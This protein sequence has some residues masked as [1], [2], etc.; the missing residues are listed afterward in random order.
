MQVYRGYANGRQEDDQANV[1]PRRKGLDGMLGWPRGHATSMTLPAHSEET[2]APKYH[3]EDEF[4]LRLRLMRWLGRQHW[5]TRGGDAVLRRLHHPDANRHYLFEVDFFGKRYRGDLAHYIDWVVFCYGGAPLKELAL[6]RE[7][8]AEVRRLRPGPITCYDVGANVGHH[9]LFMSGI[10]DRVI[11]FEPFAA[12]RKQMEDK[13][14]L[15]HIKNVQI[16]PVALGARDEDLAY[17][18]GEGANSGIG[19]FV[20]ENAPQN[21]VSH[22]LP[23]RRG[24][25]LFTEKALPVIDILK[26][27]VEGFE[28]NVFEGLVER[29]AHD[30]PVIVTEILDASRSLIGGDAAFRKFFYEGAVFAEVQGPLNSDKFILRPYR[31]ETSDEVVIVPPEMAEFIN[32]RIVR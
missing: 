16:I 19:T 27:D 1:A 22:V 23:V 14:S 7:L 17:F 2:G 5:W 4:P 18:P 31:Y 15:N 10:V 26:V 6:L 12:V 11:A 20:V 25:T 28:A 9:T 3:L 29:I 21:R 32:S 8:A 13:I 24:D 30:R